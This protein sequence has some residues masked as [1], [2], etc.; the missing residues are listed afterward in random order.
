MFA[1]SPWGLVLL[2]VTGAVAGTLNVV[3]GG[4][5]FLTLPLMIFLG[6][7]PGMANG[8]N[9]VALLLQNAGAVWGFRRHKVLDAQLALRLAAPAVVGAALGSWMALQVSDDAFRRLLAILMLLI[10]LW[11]MLRP[12][13][14]AVTERDDSRP[15]GAPLLGLFFLIGIYGG[16]VQAGVGFILLAGTTAA[17]LDL[18]RGNAVKVTCVLAWT[19]VTILVF[20]SGG[21]IHWGAG[22]TLG[23]GN[24]IGGQVGVRLT[25]LKGHEWIRWFV[26]ATVVLFA[27]RLWFL[28]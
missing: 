22:V 20:A 2:L 16:F 10:T 21:A 18:V 6:L 19:V 4:G 14:S 24:L 5:S 1:D 9:R 13:R 3:A 11:T 28:G 15:V 25:V 26:S 8:T 7:P 12:P 17:G 27:L 23:I